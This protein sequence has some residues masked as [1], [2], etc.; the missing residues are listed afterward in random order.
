M[1]IPASNH[2][3][4]HL[5]KSAPGGVPRRRHTTRNRLIGAAAI[6]AAA[7][8]AVL[9]LRDDSAEQVSSGS[10]VEVTPT[11]S[12]TATTHP[13]DTSV[14]PE[15]TAVLPEISVAPTTVV[16]A[17]TA[18]PPTEATAAPTTAPTIPVST[19]VATAPSVTNLTIDFTVDAPQLQPAVIATK[20]EGFVSVTTDGRLVAAGRDTVTFFDSTTGAQTATF[21]WAQDETRTV[22]GIGPD[23]VLYVNE[24][25]DDQPSTIVA[26]APA[27]DQYVEVARTAHTWGDVDP[28]LVASGI[29]LIDLT[30]TPFQFDYVDAAGAPSG[31][32]LGLPAVVVADTQ[33]DLCDFTTSSTQRR[34]AVV[35]P[36]DHGGDETFHA[37]DDL[38]VSRDDIAVLTATNYEAAGV[39]DRRLA[40]M[41]GGTVYRAD[42]WWY[43]GAVGTR[44]Y[45]AHHH[46]D[47]TVDIGVVEA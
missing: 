29:A 41:G 2:P 32:T 15:T 5:D 47:G 39:P 26:Y 3:D 1:N 20:S 19:D 14:S 10:T 11:T 37:C 38:D 44:L 35:W 45:F 23:D 43:I 25:P 13:L 22:L 31:K 8:A 7:I 24:Q 21:T 12:G 33:Q 6:A 4:P 46:G 30:G 27:G 17:V 40:I 36:V 18:A 42:H 34:V 28:E 9:V 16:S